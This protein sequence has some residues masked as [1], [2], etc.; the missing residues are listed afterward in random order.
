MTG[1]VS[2]KEMEGR[3]F[4]IRKRW[5]KRAPR[6]RWERGPFVDVIGLNT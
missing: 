2:S 4:H 3:A 5:E 1:K 6:K